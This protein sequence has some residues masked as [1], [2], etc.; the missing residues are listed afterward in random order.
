MTQAD[1]AGVTREQVEPDGAHRVGGDEHEHAERVVGQGV[2]QVDEQREQTQRERLAPRP[3]QEPQLVGTVENEVAVGAPAGP[4]PGSAG[5]GHRHTVHDASH[6]DA[7]HFRLAVQAEG[8]D[9]QDDHHH[10][11]GRHPVE[12]LARPSRS[13]RAG[14]GR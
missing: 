1:L 14:A 7:P 5:A 4:G 13:T 2:R 10:H 9:Q 3:A 6:S 11:V 8:P 12:A